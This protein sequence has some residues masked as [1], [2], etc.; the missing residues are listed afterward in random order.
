VKYFQGILYGALYMDYSSINL[1]IEDDI[2]TITLNKPENM[3]ALDLKMAGE[4]LDAL[5]KCESNDALRVIV[6][7]G[8]GKAF[9][10]GGD[11]KEMMDTKEHSS[12]LF[13]MSES[14]QKCA[15]RIREIKKPVIA[16]INGFA[17]GAGCSLAMSCDLRIASKKAKFNMGF[18]NVG[19][20]PGCGTYFLPKLVG[21]SKAFELLFLGNT[22][23]SAEAERIGLV[24]KVVEKEELYSTVDEIAKKLAKSAPVAMGYAKEL[25]NM[26]YVN[27]LQAQ[28]EMERK[29]ISDTAGTQD[30]KE[31]AGAFLKKSKSKK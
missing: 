24:N 20:A 25:L 19:L 9:S 5:E 29:C 7:R 6:L 4:L 3:N 31:R 1:E 27:N 22:I 28:F 13:E 26:S 8:E 14:I 30:F 10:A 15:M 17:V 2:A 12:R 21:H 11:I 16:A 18:V 23:D